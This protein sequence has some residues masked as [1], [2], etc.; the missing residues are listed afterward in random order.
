VSETT[1]Q[2]ASR[3]EFASRRSNR[4]RFSLAGVTLITALAAAAAYLLYQHPA[5]RVIYPFLLAIGILLC[6]FYLQPSWFRHQTRLQTLIAIYLLFLVLAG[7]AHR[8]DI[9][10]R[11][12]SGTTRQRDQGAREMTDAAMSWS[13]THPLLAL[14][15][16]SVILAACAIYVWT[17]FNW[18]KNKP[19]YGRPP[20]DKPN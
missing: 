14:V 8:F 9:T 18:L 2:L 1:P 12:G 16:V 6:P 20:N 5:L 7:I 17:V 3:Q 13:A 11:G 10:R 15:L 4:W 19:G